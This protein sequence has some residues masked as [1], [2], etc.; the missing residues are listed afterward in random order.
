MN[1]KRRDFIGVMK[2]QAIPPSY[3]SARQ[4]AMTQ[5]VA[6]DPERR[7]GGRD[8]YK[9]EIENG[10]IVAEIEKEVMPRPFLIFV[11]AQG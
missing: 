6:C 8:P 3:D 4:G 11:D 1:E 10:G 9:D 2:N 7:A 5:A